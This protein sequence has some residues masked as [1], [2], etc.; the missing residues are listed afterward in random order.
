MQVTKILV[1]SDIHTWKSLDVL[2]RD[3]TPDLLLLAGD[4]V[5]NG[6]L[7][8]PDEA[9]VKSASGATYLNKTAYKKLLKEHASAFYDFLELVG[10][11]FPIFIIRGDHDTTERGYAVEKIN[12]ISGCT[13]ISGKVVEINGLRILGL[14]FDETYK[15][16]KLR[17]LIE[18]Y[19]GTV[20]IVVTHCKT[21]RLPLI[22]SIE[23]KLIIRGHWGRGR[24]LVNG[25]PTLMNNSAS[26]GFIELKD[27]VIS[28]IIQYDIYKF[29]KTRKKK[30]S[31]ECS[32]NSFGLYAFEHPGVS[33]FDVYKWLKPYP[34]SSRY[35]KAE[36]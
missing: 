32:C 30:I 13:E 15:L 12:K 26:M 25:I 14:G 33:E 7:E 8:I 16:R 10:G 34:K 22:S 18:D 4:L 1:L 6:G 27:K 36:R 20:D 31:N 35:S 3:M 2:V 21:G 9:Y 24:F 17:P 19:K 29:W 11:Q 23:P 28:K 5:H